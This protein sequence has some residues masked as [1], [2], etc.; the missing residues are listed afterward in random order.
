MQDGS[1]E[2]LI[3]RKYF[4][5]KCG[6]VYL[7]KTSVAAHQRYECG[8]FPKFECP[9]CQRKFHQR[10]QI[11]ISAMGQLTQRFVCSQC[12]RS[13][14]NKGTLVS[15]QRFECGKS[16]QFQCPYCD[17]A[18]SQKSS[19]KTHIIARHKDLITKVST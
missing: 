9:H 11:L 14:K 16:P 10:A 4:C 18:L 2:S 5:D 12:S 19:L 17:R 7:H 3:K 8:Q 6:K 1:V 15:H 13:Y